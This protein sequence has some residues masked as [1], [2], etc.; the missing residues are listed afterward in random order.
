VTDSRVNSWQLE[1]RR[2][3]AIVDLIIQRIK[4]RVI[5]LT[6]RTGVGEAEESPLLTTVTRKRLLKTLRAAEDLVFPAVICK[7]WRSAIAL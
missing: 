5:R 1:I 2:E 7:A 4:F 6:G 3:G